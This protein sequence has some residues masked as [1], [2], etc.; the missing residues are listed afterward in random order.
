VHNKYTI[1]YPQGAA[2][3]RIIED[4]KKKTLQKKQ[5]KVHGKIKY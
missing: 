4:S 3:Q 2:L 5:C 1:G